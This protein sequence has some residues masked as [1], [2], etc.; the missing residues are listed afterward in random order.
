M[1]SMFAPVE[2]PEP[3]ACERVESLRLSL[4]SPVVAVAELPVGPAHAGIAIHRGRAGGAQLT[5]AVRTV[6][7]NQLACYCDE[8]AEGTS[9]SDALEAALSF[10]EGM[11]FLFDEDEIAVR[12]EGFAAEAAARWRA[13]VSLE[14]EQ[15][16]T[17][18]A[19]PPS[20]QGA[21]GVRPEAPASS[22]PLSKFRRLAASERP[23]AI[24]EPGRGEAR[25]KDLA[26]QEAPDRS[27]R[28]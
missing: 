24:L 6:R 28:I 20:I 13:L 21:G 4:N 10:A 26:R 15:R 17:G 14:P 18:L 5:L 1:R 12:G 9:R 27:G 23:G 7:G 19:D 25:R 3:A 22:L 16:S 8:R 2:A 11:G